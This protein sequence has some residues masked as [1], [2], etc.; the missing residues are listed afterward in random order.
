[1]FLSSCIAV[2][3]NRLTRVLIHRVSIKNYLNKRSFHLLH[4]PRDQFRL[5]S[6]VKLDQHAVGFILYYK[7]PS[8]FN[9][10]VL[11]GRGQ[12]YWQRGKVTINK[13]KGAGV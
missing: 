1:M 2:K 10:Y 5:N 9:M 4:S 13:A 12:M 3:R 7:N 6:V 11:V 8:L